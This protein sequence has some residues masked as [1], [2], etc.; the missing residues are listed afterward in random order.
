M[1]MPVVQSLQSA[2]TT[3]GK[4]FHH[5]QTETDADDEFF[6][7]FK[8]PTHPGGLCPPADLR[9]FKRGDDAAPFTIGADIVIDGGFTCA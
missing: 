8:T 7:L 9:T 4:E 1:E 5:A 2:L 3:A 6:L